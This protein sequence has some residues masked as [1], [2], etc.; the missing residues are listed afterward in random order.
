MFVGYNPISSQT[1]FNYIILKLSFEKLCHRTTGRSFN[2]SPEGA[3]FI[4]QL[5]IQ[6]LFGS[7]CVGTRVSVRVVV[8][9]MFN[10]VER[11]LMTENLKTIVTIVSQIISAI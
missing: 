9:S 5:D 1:H 3:R 11:K 6:W 7:T 10:D 8:W 2:L 4:W